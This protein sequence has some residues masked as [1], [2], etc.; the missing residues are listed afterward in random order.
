MSE[1]NIKGGISFE[2]QKYGGGRWML[3]SVYDDKELA[4]TEAKSLL[5]RF[6]A[7]PAVRVVAVA[8]ENGQFRE[9]TVFKQGITDDQ[10][11]MLRTLQTRPST[12]PAP[13]SAARGAEMP[14]VIRP[15]R[16][17]MSALHYYVRLTGGMIIVFGAAVLG[18]AVLRMMS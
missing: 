18:I 5:E 7:I 3:D 9:W 6:K 8:E 1:R 10:Q 16:Q 12:P 13:P 11:A 4:T 2:L 17:R 14:A 15:K